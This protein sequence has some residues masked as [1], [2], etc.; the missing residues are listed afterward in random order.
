MAEGSTEPIGTLIL[1]KG[2]HRLYDPLLTLSTL[3]AGFVRALH[4][5]KAPTSPAAWKPAHSI[6]FQ[7]ARGGHYLCLPLAG[8]LESAIQGNQPFQ[9]RIAVEEIEQPRGL[10]ILG[11]HAELFAKSV[12]P[13]FVEFFENNLKWIKDKFSEDQRRWPALWQFAWVVRNA[14]SHG[15]YVTIY[16]PT[17]PPVIWRGLMFRPS[18]SNQEVISDTT[19][20]FADIVIL[21]LEMSDLLD[22]NGCPI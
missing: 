16:D 15:G 14:V 2:K 19:L 10:T 21:M 3:I 7:S 5:V 18:D 9:L 11:T 1:E 20:T 17:F 22:S 13:I 6:A 12:T 4:S 8:L